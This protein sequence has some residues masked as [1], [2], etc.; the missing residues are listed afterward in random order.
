MGSSRRPAAPGTADI[1]SARRE[2]PIEPEEGAATAA[3]A[4]RLSTQ[5]RSANHRLTLVLSGSAIWTVAA[6]RSAV[7]ALM[8]SPV[9]SGTVWLTD[10]ILWDGDHPPGALP[11]SA[12]TR[13]IGGECG[14]LIYDAWSGFDPDGFGAASG[15]LR[16]ADSCCS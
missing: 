3:L 10:R 9:D 11:L 15:T 7:A 6:A 14:L 16:G 13:L 5:A 8:D 2:A 12:G 4:R 1:L